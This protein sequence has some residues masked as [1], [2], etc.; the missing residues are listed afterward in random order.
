MKLKPWMIGLALPALLVDAALASDLPAQEAGAW[1]QRVADS[2]RRLNYEG[3]F[4]FQQGD[5]MQT[6]RIVSRVVG[7]YK[8]TQLFALDGTPREVVCRGGESLVVTTEGGVVRTER[9]PSTRHFPDLLP[10]NANALVNW[11]SVRV[12][13]MDRVAGLECRW[14]VLVPRDAFRWGYHLCVEK[15]SA[16]PLKAMMVNDAGRPLQQFAFTE[17]RIGSNTRPASNARA[18]APAEPATRAQATEVITVRQLP[19]GYTRVA[20]VKRRLPNRPNEVDQWVFSDGL[21]HISLF[22]EPAVRPVETVK[23]ESPH[24][25]L[26]LLT[27]QVGSWQVTVLGDA[28]WP[29]IETIATN[30]AER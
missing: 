24:G 25:M 3:K 17:I 4:V 14:L 10:V 7:P 18:Q 26:N 27:R 8:E 23:G 28:P 30:L 11:Y 6:M 5:S 20:A 1:L 15:D 19:P 13:E 21:T 16:L 12:G 9:R 22:I 2:A 29:A